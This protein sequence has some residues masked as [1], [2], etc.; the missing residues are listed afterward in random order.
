MRA[1]IFDIDG[2]LTDLWPLERQILLELLKLRTSQVIDRL[3][4]N[5]KN[6]YLIYKK[7]SK[8]NDTFANFRRKYKRKL[9]STNQIPNL[10]VFN[11]VKFIRKNNDKYVFLYATSSC[12]LEAEL[13][14]K[15]LT[16]LEFFD[17]RS[18]INSDNCAYAKKTGVPF[19]KIITSYP[20]SVLITDSK[21]DAKGAAKAN[22]ATLVIKPNARITRNMID[23]V[24]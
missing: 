10:Q 13:I 5:Q 20:Q 7:M 16:T 19:K 6:P 22:V 2:T 12:K 21:D 15:K 24:K 23:K 1:L 17:L 11:T 9:Q 18:S 4:S 8:K 3:H 14:L